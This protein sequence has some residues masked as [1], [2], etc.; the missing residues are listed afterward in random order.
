MMVDVQTVTASALGIAL[1]ACCGFRVFVPMLVAGIAGRFDLFSFSEHYAWLS[2]TPALI[3]LGTATVAEIFAYYIPFVDNILDTISAPLAMVAGSML[4]IAVIPADSEWIK[5]LVGII[6]GGGGAGLI[7]A[8]T[9]FLRLFSSK[10]TL[11]T[12]NVMVATGENTAA[13]GGS[14]LSF[15]IPVI[16]AALFILLFIWVIRKVFSRFGRKERGKSP[17]R[18]PG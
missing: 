15:V 14:I 11:G 7:A 3:A 9:G 6:A 16:M 13:V 5:W 2:S 17:T 4:A 8:G 18:F 12:G 1:A 10:T